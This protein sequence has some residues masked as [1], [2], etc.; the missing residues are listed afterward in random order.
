MK[1]GQAQKIAN[2]QLD[3]LRQ[4]KQELTKLLDVKYCVDRVLSEREGK[5]RKTRPLANER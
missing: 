4:R 1:L 3:W 2:T 5:G